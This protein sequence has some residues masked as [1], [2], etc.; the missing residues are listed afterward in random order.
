MTLLFNF[1]YYGNK[2]N[3]LRRYIIIIEPF[4]DNFQ[5]KKFFLLKSY[6]PQKIEIILIIKYVVKIQTLL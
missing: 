2:K 5:K 3:Q 1:N 6:C 4:V